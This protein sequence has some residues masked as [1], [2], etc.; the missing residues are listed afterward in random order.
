MSR[1]KI[2]YG[3]GEMGKQAL[4]HFSGIT[5]ND[6]YCFAD[7]FKG[8]TEH[9]GIP[10]VSFSEFLLICKDYDIVV[11]I[12]DIVKLMQKFG[13]YGVEDFT[14][15]EDTS[16][17]TK[18]PC[19]EY[20]K[21]KKYEQHDPRQKILYGAGYFG[22]QALHYYG[23]EHVHAFV[24]RDKQ[25]ET[26][27]GKQVLNPSDLN[28]MKDEYEIIICIGSYA[29]VVEYLKSMGVIDYKIF[30]A[31]DDVRCDKYF[32]SPQIMQ[33][34]ID[35]M[36]KID[37]IKNPEYIDHYTDFYIS[38]FRQIAK[39]TKLKQP[40]RFVRHLDENKQYG[41]YNEIVK[42][43]ER[44]IEYYEAPS[45]HHSY[46]FAEDYLME[47]Q[48]YN[49]I[50]YGLAHRTWIHK[51]H[52]HCLYFAIGPVM[53]YVEPFYSN[54]QLCD[55]KSEWGR[56]LVIF[57][58]H[59]NLFSK[60]TFDLHIFIE[61][62]IEYAKS[63]NVNTIAVCSYWTDYNSELIQRFQSLGVRVVSAGFIDDPMFIRRLKSILQLADVIFTSSLGSHVGH[64]IS[65]RIPVKCFSQEVDFYSPVFS[66]DVYYKHPSIVKLTNALIKNGDSGISEDLIKA[67]DPY[68][69]FSQLKSKAE[70]GAIMDLSK[71]I[72]FNSDY[73]RS[74][75]IE[76]IRKT[77][78]DLQALDTDEGKLQF[79]L[80]KESL[81]HD[82]KEYLGEV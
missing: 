14:I 2:L 26:Y 54:D 11:T 41:I 75:Y 56:T 76:G 10:V 44:T 35:E 57:P 42:Y 62:A 18:Q 47:I 15:Y 59:T 66:I 61:A 3:A 81:P 63:C 58:A 4:E 34:Q 33:T 67:F 30:I 25:K 19:K 51:H 71:L 8:G 80:M 82:Y 53:N 27:C 17:I 69:G 70:M 13:E 23:E 9:C 38:Y 40:K 36:T 31:M 64:A 77:Y 16:K 74:R 45:V 5:P 48:W 21:A 12:Y 6:V 7:C 46:G 60:V 39:I 50:Q 1:K 43:A 68:L 28:G 72:I 55:I 37:F 78:R 22:K 49:L 20:S 52:K 65:M 79:S 29:K 73:K 24:D 32:D